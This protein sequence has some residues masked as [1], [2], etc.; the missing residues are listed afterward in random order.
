M[1]TTKQAVENDMNGL[2]GKMSKERKEKSLHRAVTDELVCSRHIEA[3]Q[4]QLFTPTDA[5]EAA[6][7]LALLHLS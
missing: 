5:P 7:T 4:F 3:A 1:S 6:S 2:K